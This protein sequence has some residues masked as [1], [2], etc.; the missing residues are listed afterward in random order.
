MTVTNHSELTATFVMPAS[1]VTINADAHTQTYNISYEYHLG[2]ATNPATYT[3]EDNFT[4][5]EP[6]R[7]K[8]VFL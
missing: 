2:T 4:L 3:V 7:E 8:S 1:T 6:T 5:N